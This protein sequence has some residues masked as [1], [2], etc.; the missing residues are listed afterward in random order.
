MRKL[1]DVLNETQNIRAQMDESILIL[2]MNRPKALNAL[3][4]Q[5]LQELDLL[6]DVI[7]DDESIKGVILRAKEK[8]LLPVQTSARCSLT[9]AKKEGAMRNVHKLYLIKSR[10]LKSLSSQL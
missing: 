5:T 7:R 2:T 6:F 10:Q 4:D 3:N 8:H 9:E 1:Q